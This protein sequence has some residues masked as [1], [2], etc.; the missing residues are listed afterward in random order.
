MS[1]LDRMKQIVDAGKPINPESE[2]ILKTLIHKAIPMMSYYVCEDVGEAIF[3]DAIDEGLSATEIHI[4]IMMLYNSGMYNGHSSLL[5]DVDYRAQKQL[6]SERSADLARMNEA[7]DEK[8]MRHT[9][10]KKEV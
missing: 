7:A 8:K 2:K 9:R 5:G 3:N 4:A 10:K 6:N 1:R